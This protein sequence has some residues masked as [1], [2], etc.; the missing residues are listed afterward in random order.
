MAGTYSLA[1]SSILFATSGKSKPNTS[2]YS[3]SWDSNGPILSYL[4]E[5]PM[6]GLWF[7]PEGLNEYSSNFNLNI[8]P[9]PSNESTQLSFELP[10]SSEVSIEFIDISG[11]SILKLSPKQCI[12]GRNEIQLET[13]DLLNGVYFVKLSTDFGSTT[14]RIIIQ[15]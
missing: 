7:N 12:E 6:V 8:A 1:D 9:N 13:N 4:T 3:S 14:K 2:F 11:K 10:A 15:H 5:T